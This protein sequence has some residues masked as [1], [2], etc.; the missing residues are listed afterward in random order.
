MKK[1]FSILLKVDTDS[2]KVKKMNIYQQ[3]YSFL[4]TNIHSGQNFRQSLS[5]SKIVLY[6]NISRQK[7]HIR[8][9][10]Y[11]SGMTQTYQAITSEKHANIQ[12]F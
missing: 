12:S 2:C 5:L 3:D 6:W 7:P 11:I 10:Y 4:D 1:S 8:I 9:R